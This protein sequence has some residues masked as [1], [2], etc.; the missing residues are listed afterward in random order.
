MEQN[1]E[2]NAGTNILPEEEE[3]G[4]ECLSTWM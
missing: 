1:F 3:W 2:T 4:R